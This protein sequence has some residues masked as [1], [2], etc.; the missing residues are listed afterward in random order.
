MSSHVMV[1]LGPVGRR[2]LMLLRVRVRSVVRVH[3]AADRKPWYRS[4]AVE[5]LACPRNVPTACSGAL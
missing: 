2:I 4:E 1:G 3:H 5:S